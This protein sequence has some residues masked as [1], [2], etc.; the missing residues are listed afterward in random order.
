MQGEGGFFS[1]DH[2][3]M[4]GTGGEAETLENINGR[5]RV[6]VCTH[7]PSLLAVLPLGLIIRHGGGVVGSWADGTASSNSRCKPVCR[8]FP[9]TGL[10]MATLTSPAECCTASAVGSPNNS[11]V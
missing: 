3:I 7:A 6:V 4:M 2:M 10:V 9:C 1:D 5:D 11:K 8:S